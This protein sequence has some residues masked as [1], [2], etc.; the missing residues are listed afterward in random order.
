MPTT[1]IVSSLL[2]LLIGRFAGC[3][4]ASTDRSSANEASCDGL[5]DLP[6]VEPG[7]SLAMLHSRLENSALQ[8]RKPTLMILGN[9]PRQRRVGDPIARNARLRFKK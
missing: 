5:A 9:F 7:A 3:S 6:A 8:L 4:L 1:E 2:R